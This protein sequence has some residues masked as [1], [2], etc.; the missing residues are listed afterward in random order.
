MEEYNFQ[1]K[2]PETR[3]C[4]KHGDQPYSMGC[5][6]CLIVICVR[7]YPELKACT[8]SGKLA[9]GVLP[10]FLNTWYQK[11]IVFTKK[12]KFLQRNRS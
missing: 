3:A 8:V 11:I 4:K 2:E 12:P 7:C 6:L 1:T 10:C 9:E 5:K